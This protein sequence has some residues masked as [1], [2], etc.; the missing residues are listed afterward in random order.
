MLSNKKQMKDG[1]RVTKYYSAP[2]PPPPPAFLLPPTS[3][4]IGITLRSL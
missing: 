1:T 2:N 3:S 4:K